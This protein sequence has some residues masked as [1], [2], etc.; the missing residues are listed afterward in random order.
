MGRTLKDS[1]GNSIEYVT[2]RQEEYEESLKFFVLFSWQAL[3]L[4]PQMR[5]VKCFATA[6]RE[7]ICYRILWNISL[8][9]MWNEINPLMPAGISLAV[10]KFHARS[11]FHKSRK[12]FISLRSVLKN[13]ALI[14]SPYFYEKLVMMVMMLGGWYNINVTMLLVATFALCFKF[15]RYVPDAVFF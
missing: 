9:S 1:F 6:K 8:C 2:Y 4:C 15:K 7:I 14:V 11:V 5:I 13:T 3:H 12:G 10:G